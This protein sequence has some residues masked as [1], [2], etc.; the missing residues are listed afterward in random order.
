MVWEGMDARLW[1]IQPSYAKQSKV[2]ARKK[3]PRLLLSSYTFY[4]PDDA[5]NR[6]ML[7]DD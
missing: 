2:H 7:S 1:S 4:P 5:A 3:Q 6:R